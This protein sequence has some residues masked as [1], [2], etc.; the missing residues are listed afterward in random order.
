MQK[1]IILDA[2][3]LRPTRL[4]C[5]TK[6]SCGEVVVISSLL[7]GLG[8]RK[9]V[10]RDHRLLFSGEGYVI[11]DLYDRVLEE[12]RVDDR[13]GRKQVLAYNWE[14]LNTRI[15]QQADFRKSAFFPPAV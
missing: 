4:L 7:T 1:R 3:A 15:K 10:G 8:G 2:A 6:D 5:T 11:L 12:R 9:D 14:L 13:G